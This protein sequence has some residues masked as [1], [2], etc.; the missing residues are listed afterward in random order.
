M[1]ALWENFFTAMV[2]KEESTAA[3]IVTSLSVS[4]KSVM[5]M[6]SSYRSK[7]ESYLVS[8]LQAKNMLSMGI[9]TPKDYTIID[10]MLAE[11]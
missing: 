2:T 3:E 5:L 9:L 8:A 7:L 10:T 6:N 11:K 1:S 4:G